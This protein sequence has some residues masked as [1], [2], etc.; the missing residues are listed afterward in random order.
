M[1]LLQLFLKNS[2]KTI[3]SKSYE[4]ST[5]FEI[6]NNTLPVILFSVLFSSSKHVNE[7]RE[8]F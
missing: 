6:E 7:N 4:G 5:E 2:C 1:M 3:Y 8:E